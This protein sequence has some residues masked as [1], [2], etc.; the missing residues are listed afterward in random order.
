MK[1]K[2]LAVEIAQSKKKEEPA[3][4]ED[5]GGYGGGGRQGLRHRIGSHW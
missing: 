3:E 5:Q 1:G 4:D 2:K